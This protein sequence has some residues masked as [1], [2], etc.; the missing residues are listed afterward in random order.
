MDRIC[1]WRQQ[2]EQIHL[3]RMWT[4]EINETQLKDRLFRQ[5][6]QLLDRLRKE[7]DNVYRLL[8]LKEQ[9]ALWLKSMDNKRQSR[10][11]FRLFLEEQGFICDDVPQDGDSFF[12]SLSKQL[13]GNKTSDEVK[14]ELIQ[15]LIDHAD[16]Y[17]QIGEEERH[18]AAAEALNVTLIIYRTDSHVPHVYERENP[19]QNCVLGY[20]VDLYYFSL[21]CRSLFYCESKSPRQELFGHLKN[22]LDRLKKEKD[23]LCKQLATPIIDHDLEKSFT[24]FAN[25]MTK[26]YSQ[27]NFIR[28]PC[29]HLMEAEKLIKDSHMVQ[30]F[31]IIMGTPSMD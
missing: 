28:N 14:N 5:F 15:H 23:K 11:C 16:L 6:C 20:E 3:N 12:H 18:K 4:E 17:P 1:H 31:S 13:R 27:E 30:Y 25:E 24:I 22:F 9:W 19:N 8:S 7:N 10:R 21:R 29:Y 26:N 2:A